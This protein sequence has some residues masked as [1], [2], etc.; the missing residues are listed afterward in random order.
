ML[1]SLFSGISG[2]RSHQQMIDVTGNNIANVNTVG[3][4]SSATLFEDTLSQL[5]R[6]AGSPQPPT[7]GTNPAQVGLGVKLA[8]IS[9]NF[10][11]GA[12]QTTGR[13]TDLMVS[14][15][16]FF[17]VSD[18]GQQLYTRAGS[19]SFDAN[20]LLVDPQGAVV[21]GWTAD[22]LGNVDTN[23]PIG[24][25]QLPVGTL[26]PPQP[27]T[28]V[29]LAGNLPGDSTST[30]PIVSS[31][32]GYDQQGNKLTYTSTFTQLS[33]ISW[34]VTVTDGTNTVTQNIA[35]Q[36]DGSTPLPTTVLLGGALIDFS[37]ITSY[38]GGTS[39]GTLK[40][41][42]SGMGAL[43]GF[44]L[45]ADGKLIGIFSNGLKQALAQLAMATFNNPNGLEKVGNSDY[46][47]TVNSGVSQLGTAGTGGRGTLQAGVLEMSNVDL[48]QEFVNLIISER[49][50]QAN[51]KVIT[52]SDEILQ[53]LVNL[54]R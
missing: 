11:Q 20:G 35:F 39:I 21:Q 14:G 33:P 10:G 40:Q 38:A 30:T 49:G 45:T 34:D 41:N 15:D 52:A 54:K 2:L 36:P 18:G 24:D 8:G 32:T 25:V 46:R 4:K 51:S 12:A 28:S 43:Q 23:T 6:T 16:G 9:T 17:V 22:K 27:T 44:T 53:D 37:G 7:G 50:F 29:T 13:S 5:L 47:T 3:Y 31:I 26:L 48:G 19:F 42:G 1:R